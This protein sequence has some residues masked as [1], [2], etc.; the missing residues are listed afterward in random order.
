[1]EEGEP[2]SVPDWRRGGR[3][4]FG[5]GGSRSTAKGTR[6][7]PTTRSQNSTNWRENNQQTSSSVASPG[8]SDSLVSQSIAEGRRIYIGNMPYMA[9]P[10]D[11]EALFAD[12]GYKVERI[13]ISIDPFTGRNPSY[14]FVEL[15]TKE[16]AD[17][18]MSELNGTELLGRPLKIGPGVAKSS[19]SRE[20]PLGRRGGKSENREGGSPPFVFDRWKRTDAADHWHGVSDKGR[21]LYVGGLPRMPDQRTVDDEIRKLFQDFTIDAVSKI[22]SPHISTRAK[23]GNHFYLFVDFPT[24]E[25]AEAAIMA[26]N[27]KSAPWGGR[28][29]VSKA[30]GDSRRVEERERWREEE[31]TATGS[32][33]DPESPE[34]G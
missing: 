20:R 2:G 27:G 1:M 31:L 21:R 22:I 28:L 4:S 5:R 33:G 17:R 32:T 25:E 7:T 3:A 18:V 14:C 13:D 16:H 10:E 9:K 19:A 8:E 29:V 24:A 6:G 23:P 12:K 15:E 34:F 11:V 26:L 30:R